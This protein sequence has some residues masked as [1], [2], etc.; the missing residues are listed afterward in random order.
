MNDNIKNKQQT[1]TEIEALLSK[2]VQQTEQLHLY[3]EYMK[4]VFL[5]GSTDN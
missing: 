5:A 2:K 4:Q 3:C 1:L